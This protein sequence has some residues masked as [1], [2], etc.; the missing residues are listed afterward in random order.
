MLKSEF[1]ER[2]KVPHWLTGITEKKKT[3]TGKSQGIREGPRIQTIMSSN[4]SEYQN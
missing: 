3:K 4:L 1:I 2:I